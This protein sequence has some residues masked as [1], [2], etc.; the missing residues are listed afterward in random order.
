MNRLEIRSQPRPVRALLGVLALVWIAGCGAK[1]RASEELDIREAV[2]RYQF[3]NDLEMGDE[4][5]Y[6]AIVVEG[7]DQ[8][9]DAVF[10]KRFAH[11]RPTVFKA[12]DCTYFPGRGFR[13]K[14]TGHR[15][16]IFSTGTI[17]WV[18]NRRVMVSGGYNLGLR[19]AQDT[20]HLTK[21]LGQWRVTKRVRRPADVGDRAASGR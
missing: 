2:Y 17:T 8:D 16:I 9:P 5:P 21:T 13:N 18:S 6:L 15:G 7:Q 20:F 3:G 10:M 1:D 4:G 12:S 14:R 11:C 19:S